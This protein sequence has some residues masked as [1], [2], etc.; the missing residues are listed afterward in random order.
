LC[1]GEATDP[2]VRLGRRFAL[3][4]ELAEALAHVEGLSNVSLSARRGAAQLK[5]VA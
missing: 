1:I 3:D 5:L 4:G 2:L